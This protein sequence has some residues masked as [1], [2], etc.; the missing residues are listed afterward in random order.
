VSDPWAD[1]VRRRERPDGRALERGIRWEICVEG[2]RRPRDLALHGLRLPSLDAVVGAFVEDGKPTPCQQC[3]D[4]ARLEEM[5][6]AVWLP[7]ARRDV[8]IDWRR[9]RGARYVARDRAGRMVE[10]TADHPMLAEVRPATALRAALAEDD[11]GTALRRFLVAESEYP[12]AMRELA[13][14]EPDP[15]SARAWA[16]RAVARVP[17]DPE[18]WLV[19]GDV[20]E[21]DGSPDSALAAFERAVELDPSE[22]EGHVSRGLVLE[23]LGRKDDAL[24]AW[25]QG[26]RHLPGNPALLHNVA[27]IRHERGE[28][29]GVC[30]AIRRLDADCV[31]DLPPPLVDSL[32]RLAA[33]WGNVFAESGDWA[34]AL[35]LF[36]IVTRC[37]DDALAW[38]CLAQC[39]EG[40][41]ERAAAASDAERALARDPRL[42]AARRLRDRCRR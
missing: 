21:R 27:V 10:I 25:H 13:R 17:N 29:E 1:L 30:D 2:H 8:M 35:P 3:G 19:L 31:P 38:L 14:L 34:R 16:E 7:H 11:A 15:A 12:P 42:A 6:V 41:G 26:L 32:H 4:H 39:R 40:M 23:R 20:L 33:H 37:A 22:A 9:D 18:G 36:T 28:G 24:R 5:Q